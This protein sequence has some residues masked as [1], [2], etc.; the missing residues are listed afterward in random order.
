MRAGEDACT[1][2]GSGTPGAE[3]LALL[4]KEASALVSPPPRES[5]DW[6]AWYFQRMAERLL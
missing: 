2:L 5:T 4:E 6:Y 1:Q 3:T